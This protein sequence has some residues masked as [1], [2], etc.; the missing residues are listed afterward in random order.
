[1]IWLFSTSFDAMGYRNPAMHQRLRPLLPD[2][3]NCGFIG[4]ASALEWREISNV[5]EE[6]PLVLRLKQWI[7]LM[8]AMLLLHCTDFSGTNAPWG[9]LNVNLDFF[10]F[11][12]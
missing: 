5:D 11:Q 6:D 8:Q 3:K 1:M 7:L 10:L 2:I 4:R 12:Q 9:E